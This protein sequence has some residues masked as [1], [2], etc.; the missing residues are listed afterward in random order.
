MLTQRELCFCIPT[1]LVEQ[2][3]DEGKSC[4]FC[5]VAFP[6]HDKIVLCHWMYPCS[7]R[8]SRAHM[9]SIPLHIECVLAYH[10]YMEKNNYTRFLERI[11]VDPYHLSLET[12]QTMLDDCRAKHEPVGISCGQCKVVKQRGLKFYTCSQCK[13]VAYCSATCQKKNWPKHKSFCNDKCTSDPDPHTPEKNEEPPCV[14][15]SDTDRAFH[16]KEGT[17]ICSNPPCTN[18]VMPPYTLTMRIGECRKPQESG[19]R[20]HIIGT[21]YCSIKCQG[22]GMKL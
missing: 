21:Q 2:N 7:G 17:G 11:V 1:W 9:L 10:E 18:Y 4:G 16:E 3:I 15:Y 5:K 13:S 6:S 19:K 20:M 22:K 12:R 14:C 8:L